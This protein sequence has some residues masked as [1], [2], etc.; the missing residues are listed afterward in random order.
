MHNPHVVTLDGIR[1]IQGMISFYINDIHKALHTGTL[2]SEI[3]IRGCLL[4]HIYLYGGKPEL[5]ILLLL[6]GKPRIGI[7]IPK[8]LII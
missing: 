7:F 5:G 4:R 6:E 8:N 3:Y 1:G 2:N